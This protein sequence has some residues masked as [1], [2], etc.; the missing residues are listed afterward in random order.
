MPALLDRVTLAPVGAELRDFLL[1]AS[2]HRLYVTDT[3]GQLHVLDSATHETLAILPAAGNLTLDANHDRLYVS[4]GD[5][6]GD[7]TVVDTDSLIVVGTVAPGGSVAVDSVRDRRTP[8]HPDS[9]RDRILDS[10]GTRV[11]RWA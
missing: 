6:D 3:A 7:V 2:A 5:D 9:D 11:G 4:P 8:R 1:D 10:P